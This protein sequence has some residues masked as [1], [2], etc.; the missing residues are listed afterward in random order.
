MKKVVA[1]DVVPRKHPGRWIAAIGLLGLLAWVVQFAVTNPALQLHV[2]GQYLFAPVILAGVLLTIELTVLATVIGVLLGVLLA[3]CRLSDNPVL[4]AFATSYIWIFR[5]TPVLVQLL[6]WYFLGTILPQ[7]SIG[8]PLTDVT[9]WS[10]P[11]NVVITQFTAAVLGLGLN[12]AAYMAET[13]RGGIQAVPNGQIEAARALG[14]SERDK[15]IRI[16]L[17]QAARVA[18]PPM[19]NQIITLLKLTSM[20]VVI[21]LPELLTSAQIIYSRTFQQIPLL[22]VA[23]LWYLVLTT[24]LTYIQSR[25]ERRLAHR[26]AG[27]SRPAPT[28]ATDEMVAAH[29]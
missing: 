3:V 7:I 20:V 29:G 21:G 13:I 14:I 23:S 6:F 8:I 9:F 11:T 15:L 4:R 26:P 1:H 24:L 5:G 18:I 12:E 22:I 17:P 27:Q 19:G 10:A 28:K 2:V 16:V 25:I